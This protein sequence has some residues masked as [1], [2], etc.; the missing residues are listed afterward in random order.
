MQPLRI[1]LVRH[2]RVII[3]W[4]KNPDSS[5]F[6]EQ[7]IY[8][9]DAPIAPLPA[10]NIPIENVYVS[11]YPRSA[12]TAAFLVGSKKIEKNP[13][14]NEVPIRAFAKTRM[15]LPFW[16]WNTMATIQWLLNS[17][18]ALEPRRVTLRRVAAFLNLLEVRHEDCILVGHGIYFYEM[19][20]MMHRRGFKGRLHRHMAN[21]EA[22]EFRLD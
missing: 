3:N 22:L 12:A 13:L 11:E 2:G 17:P 10:M 7:N 16:F 18:R 1:V 5:T 6:D 15:H 14:M 4:D 20:L 21:G 9:D 8:Y 19:M